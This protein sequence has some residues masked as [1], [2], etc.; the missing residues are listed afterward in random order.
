VTTIDAIAVSSIVAAGICAFLLCSRER[1]FLFDDVFYADA[2]RS[3]IDNGFYGIQGRPEVNQPP[4]LPALLGLLC[5]AVSCSHLALVRAMV[6]C[7]TAGL[8]AAH[9]LLRRLAPPSVGAGICI[10][11]AIAMPWVELETR[12]LY[13]CFPFLL[14]SF[15]ALFA[16]HRAET[17]NR[18]STRVA[19]SVAS[20][21]SVSAS[22]LT[23][24]AGI[25]L[26]GAM[27]ARVALAFLRAPPPRPGAP[28]SVCARADR[29]RSGPGLLDA[30]RAGAA[31]MAGASGIPRELPR[32]GQGAQ[33]KR[34]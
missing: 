23:A 15:L 24:S 20:C 10:L 4:G 31:G 30:A 34:A 14:T 2:G 18:R 32:A 25:A 9:A 26:L 28:A 33:R 17:V 19:W 27:A 1:G 7:A 22:I 6:V 13:P 11:L 21:V 29:R 12:Y 16:L 8:L 3:L 5:E